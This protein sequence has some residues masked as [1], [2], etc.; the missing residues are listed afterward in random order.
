[1]IIRRKPGPEVGWEFVM[2]DGTPHQDWYRPASLPIQLAQQQG[3]E[4]QAALGNVTSF[5]HPEARTI[6]TVGGGEGFDLH[7]CVQALFAM[8]L[9]DQD[10]KA[11]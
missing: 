8:R 9:P 3:R 2:R 5:R 4:R 6:Q 10:Q 11:A 7:E 1:M